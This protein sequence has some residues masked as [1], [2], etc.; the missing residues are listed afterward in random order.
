MLVKLF[1]EHIGKHWPTVRKAITESSLP[2]T[3]LSEDNILNIQKGLML[4]TM[5]CWA[6][7]D[8]ESK[9]LKGLVITT[10]AKDACINEVSLLIYVVYG[11]EDFTLEMWEAGFK[12]L[13]IYAKSKGCTSISGYSAVPFIKSVARRV[14]GST[15][16]SYIKVPLHKEV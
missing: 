10:F 14:G 11:I 8:Q 15:D 4:G 7:T 5:D 3:K 6:V 13:S 2:G 12:Q 1:P 9:S 16:I